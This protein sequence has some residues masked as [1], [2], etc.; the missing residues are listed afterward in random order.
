VIVG[1]NS[2]DASIRFDRPATLSSML[3]PLLLS[4]I[5]FGA[6]LGDGSFIVNMKA[7]RPL[8][9]LAMQR[10][11]SSDGSEEHVAVHRSEEGDGFA[12]GPRILAEDR[13]FVHEDFQGYHDQCAGVPVGGEYYWFRR[14]G[15]VAD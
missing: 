2:C 15:R 6:T 7:T 13:D 10:A 12:V 3:Y 8:I 11:I 1:I 14:T 9:D 4:N 5:N